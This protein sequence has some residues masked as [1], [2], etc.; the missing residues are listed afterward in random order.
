MSQMAV[1]ERIVCSHSHHHLSKAQDY[2][3]LADVWESV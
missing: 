3:H 2:I 1:G